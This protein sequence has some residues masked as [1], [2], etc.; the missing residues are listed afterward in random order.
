MSQVLEGKVIWIGDNDDGSKRF[1]IADTDLFVNADE[2]FASQIQ[3]FGTIKVAVVQRGKKHFVERLKVLAAPEPARGKSGGGGYRQGGGGGFKGG[4]GQSARDKYFED[5]DKYD[6]EVREPKIHYQSAIKAAHDTVNLLLTH[7]ALPLGSGKAEKKEE[8]IL[9]AIERYTY[10][11]WKSIE[12]MELVA[13]H[14][15]QLEEDPEVEQEEQQDDDGFDDAPS[16]SDDG[17]DDD[18]DF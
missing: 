3:K 15:A 4:G 13:K 9:Q 17:F 2:P 12:G 5:K 14:K 10:R 7:S 18:V 16:G 8:I 1:K 6:K 11:W